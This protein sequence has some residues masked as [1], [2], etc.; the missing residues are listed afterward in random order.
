MAADTRAFIAACTVCACSKTSHQPSPGL[1]CPLPV[2]GRP[3]SHI[4]LDFVTGLPPS[5]GNTTIL[6]IVD[7][8]SK[9]AHFVALPKL[10]TALE[11]ADLLISHAFHL[12]RT[13]TDIVSDRG[14][15]FISQVWKAFCKALGATM[16]LSSGHHPQMNGQT[17]RANQDL[18]AELCC[19][20]F[21]NPSSW[22]IHL[23]WVEYAQSQ[24]SAATGMSPFECAMGFQPPLFPAQE[25]EVS[26]PSVQAHLRDAVRFGDKHVPPCY[27]PLTATDTLQ[28]AIGDQR[29]TSNQVRKFGSPPKISL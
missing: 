22:S 25:D 29:L 1:L 20:A 13:P 15:Q 3:W 11:T 21:S 28:I 16:S 5:Q 27:A 17:E 8:F 2:P 4:A 9:T 10:P 23:S 26:V 6:T 14:P 18:E 24:P 12:H 19:V 7:R